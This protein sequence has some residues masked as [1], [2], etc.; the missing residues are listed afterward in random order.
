MVLGVLGWV[1]PKIKINPNIISLPKCIIRRARNYIATE[2]L[3]TSTIKWVCT[4]CSGARESKP[5]SKRH[6]GRLQT[7]TEFLTACSIFWKTT[8]NSEL[9]PVFCRHGMYARPAVIIS[10]TLTDAFHG[11]H[12]ARTGRSWDGYGRIQRVDGKTTLT[13]GELN[14]TKLGQQRYL[15]YKF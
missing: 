12:G 4:T 10:A 13:I 5:S 8:T 2:N 3:I 1:I 9:L 11:L 15:H 7:S 6:N 14:R